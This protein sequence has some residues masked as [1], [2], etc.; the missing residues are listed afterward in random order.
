MAGD[1]VGIQRVA[2]LGHLCWGGGID[3][4]VEL[5]CCEERGSSELRV[6]PV[7]VGQLGRQWRIR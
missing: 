3:R 5:V 2:E 6:T 7:Y 4:C 1:I